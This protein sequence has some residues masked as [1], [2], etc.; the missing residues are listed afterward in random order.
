VISPRQT[1]LVRA[2]EL[3]TFRRAIAEAI[4]AGQ[5]GSLS[6]VGAQAVL[7]PT[8]AAGD[9]LRR[10]L[11]GHPVDL[12][13]GS[14][15]SAEILTRDELY[16][17]LHS[18][19]GVP[20][21]LTAFEREVLLRQAARAAAAG[22]AAP[23]FRLRPGLI[24]QMLAFYDELH[25][26][27]RTLEAFERLMLDALEPSAEIDRG[28][29]R[30]LEQTRFLLGAFREYEARAAATS[31]LDEHAL[32]RLALS[33]AGRSPF[34]HVIVTIG[35]RIADPH[36][37]WTA[38]FDLLA[39]LP[40]LE[41]LD[42]IATERTLASGYHQRL[43][44]LLPGIEERTVER[45]EAGNPVLI[46][47]NDSESRLFLVRDREVELADAARTVK[48]RFRAGALSSP[49]RFAVI[50]QRPL[51]Y[52]Y[53]ARH[54]LADARMAFQATD[55]LPLAGEPLAAALDLVLS[56]VTSG[57]T[58]ATGIA[59][60]RSP[61]LWLVAYN[62]QMDR[63][64]S[65]T[66]GQPPE[67]RE[68]AALERALLEARFVGGLSAL[69]A[70]AT[71]LRGAPERAMGPMIRAARELS[72]VPEAS[73][74]SEQIGLLAAFMRAHEPPSPDVMGDR[75]A[76]ARGAI[77]GALDAL[78]SAHA[79]HDDSPL[80]IEELAGTIRRWIESQT[81]SPRTGTR[82]VQLAEAHAAR[83]GDFDEIR[84]VGLVE[85]D[86]PERLGRNVFYPASLLNQLGWTPDPDRLAGARAAF[87][88]LLRLPAVRTSAS[89]FTLEDDAIVAVSP[90]VEELDAADLIV[91]REK[92]SDGFRM[93]VHEALSDDPVAEAVVGGA[94]AEWLAARRAR[95]PASDPRYRGYIGAR[96]PD[97]YGVNAVEQ[98][99]AC[100]FKYFATTVLDLEEE[101]EDEPGLTRLE[102]GQFVHEVLCDFFRAWQEAG[103]GAITLENLPH[104]V[105]EFTRIAEA[106]LATL[107]P[108][109]RA[110]ERT[111]LLGSAAASGL[112]GRAFAFE[113]ERRVP[114]VERLLEHRLEGSFTFSDGER[115]RQVRVRGKAD[116]ID[117]LPDRSIRVIDYKLRRAPNP[118][119]A[120]QLPIYGVA[121]VQ[122]LE[123][124]RGG[125]WRLE[126][127][128][129]VA[130]GE[131]QAFVRL[132]GR[133]GAAGKMAEAVD[134]GQTL[135]LDVVDAIERGEFP[136][137][138]EEP[139]RCRFCAYPSVCRKDY[140]G[141]E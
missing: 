110:L 46:V 136:V 54:V 20:G 125:S 77:L 124:S 96:A 74:A 139:F 76:R 131:R 67:P 107:P 75:H 24:V 84:I 58:R 126:E 140:V 72:P 16:E 56:F 106:K 137:R 35:D 61:H 57:F 73:T 80:E 42:V 99:V 101:K 133:Q 45:V 118:K 119:R 25:R 117:V 33:G 90:F 2:P 104:A 49:D 21:R 27:G 15:G 79:S 95:T 51:P 1:T 19:G 30:M 28:A 92:A 108:T 29:A 4:L 55:E 23:P 97:G 9:L 71:E 113:L 48:Q 115:R 6:A 129:Y 66:P 36:G 50:F 53:L 78:S 41:R 10:T 69:E 8:K 141:D 120:L 13:K 64:G 98:Y 112:A 63:E 26:R 17:R 68:I 52:L 5:D 37:L 44:D 3:R 138:P 114:V 135:F 87:Q 102:R 70:C 18:G 128:G 47:P 86:W 100:P 134:A 59:L 39:R 91:Q 11:D 14:F 127:A 109:E 123:S 65:S 88:D 130:F 111:H 82:G 83:Y 31:R 38:D 7:V 81:F 34:V 89:A 132:G 122:A 121:A 105:E 12:E 40:A 32:R 22:G 60:L 93:F 62:V 85:S 103:R 43:H 116:R 94:A